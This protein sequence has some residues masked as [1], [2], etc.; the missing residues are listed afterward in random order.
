MKTAIKLVLIYFVMQILA[1]LLVMPFA[2]LYSYAVSGTIDAASVIALAPSML[3]GFV[4]MG[5]YLW[6]KGY[7]KDDGRIWSPVSVAYLGWSIIIGLSTIF[8]IDFVMSRLSF[9]PDWMGAT[10]DVLQ[11]G[12][13]GIICISVLGP[14]LEEMLFRGA[15][16][17][18]L[19]QRYSPVKAIILSA[20]VF[21][22]FHINPA[23][24]AGAILSGG[25]FAWLYYKTG[26]LVP[27]ILIHILNNSLS[28]FLSLHYP[29][30]K[31]TSDL[32]GEPAYW[33]C[34]AVAAVLFGYYFIVGVKAGVEA[35]IDGNASEASQK[36]LMN[37]KYISLLPE[38]L[39]GLGDNGLFQD[40]IYN[41]RSG[42]YVPV[43]FN[44]MMVSVDT[45]STTLEQTAFTLLNFLHIVI[46]VWSIVLFVRLVISINR[47]DIFNWKNVHRLRLLGAAL[48]ISFCTALLPAYLTFRSVGNVF[49]VH[50]YE[51]HLSDTVNTTTLVLGISTLIVAEVFAIGLKMKEEQD[52]TI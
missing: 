38:H 39:S 27:G 4:G 9:L 18:V 44:S 12:W 48:I 25:L 2:M 30:V 1:A 14:V 46:C 29:D 40:S 37:M 17:K 42:E 31:Y 10:F 50:G 41:E 8:L 26:S 52:L 36:K 15:I 5:G 32:L 45:E 33:C 47:S 19:L 13:L 22:I 35:G 24:V 3:L 28:V 20:L 21:G 7:L 49:S 6:K 51:L 23:Q 34:L 43:S 16:T 11:S